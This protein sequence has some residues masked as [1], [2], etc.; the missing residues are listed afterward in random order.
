M[1]TGN[2]LILIFIASLLSLFFLILFLKW[3]A[4]IAL[5]VVATLT[6]IVV[7]IPIVDV[8]V[9]IADGFG[10]TLAGVGILIGLGIVLGK[11]MEFS[12]AIQKIASTLLNISGPKKSRHAVAS[13]G[14]V[15][16]IPLFF[17]AAFVI[18]NNLVRS[19]S[20]K[21]KIPYVSL[22]LPLA[23]G[24]I[25]AYCIVIPTPAPLAVADNLSLD[26][27][28][29]FIYGLIVAL[30]AIYVG[31]I[32]YGKF[33]GR[34]AKPLI[35]NAIN[36]L[37]SEQ[38]SQHEISASTE[39]RKE[40]SAGLA[41]FVILLPIALILLNTIFGLVMPETAAAAFFGFVGEKNMAL[42]ISVIVAAYLLKPY[43]KK[44]IG[45]AYTESF[46]S[47]GLIILITG[48]GGGFGSIVNETGIGDYLVSTM[49]NWNM[50]IIL[51]AFLF[52]QMLR[53][54][55]GSS[56]VSLITTSSILGPMALSLGVSPILLG[57]A[58][59]AGG[60][61]LSM[62]NDSGFWV[63]SKFAGLSVVD[64][65]KTWSFG[66]FIAGVTG[67]VIVYILSLGSGFLPGI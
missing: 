41:F 23:L 62:P 57:L 50:P 39:S 1:I 31:G 43:M 48:A 66:G 11:L 49:Q 9:I 37:A 64:T 27:G 3:D 52:A 17:D 46:K 59:C 4:F 10:S 36:N 15:V 26:L 8:P 32:V 25:V 40:I 55:L 60:I 12:G 19:L 14:L 18:L 30:G 54:A 53:V 35:E 20:A 56:T 47:A 22:V 58:I 61:G 5:L 63:V 13:T 21:A 2:L 24:L 65:L 16:G 38:E 34:N 28:L 51:L 67:L 29:F 33:V 44:D 42:L 45:E 6:G 7:G